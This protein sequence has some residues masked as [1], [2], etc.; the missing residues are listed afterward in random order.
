MKK[1]SHVFPVSTLLPVELIYNPCTIQDIV[2]SFSSFDGDV[3]VVMDNSNHP[4]GLITKAF[5]A[6]LTLSENQCAMTVN[7]LLTNKFSCLDLDSEIDDGVGEDF[8]YI[9]I[10]NQGRIIGALSGYQILEMLFREA[11]KVNLQ[12]A[13]IINSAYNAIVTINAENK[14]T[15]YNRAAEKLFG[16]PKKEIMGKEIFELI[17]NTRLDKVIQTGVV[18]YGQKLN[19]NG[20]TLLSNRAPIIVDG[21][22]IGA[23]AVLQDVTEMESLSNEL[24][25]SQKLNHELD[26]I[27]ESSFDGIYITDGAGNTLRINQAYTRITGITASEV[28]GK[29]MKELVEEGVF[30]Q[31]VTLIVMEKRIPVTIVQEVMKTGKIILVTGNPIFDENGALIRVV[32]NVRDITELNCLKKE[33]EKA[34]SL[35]EHYKEE[36]E[37]FKFLGEKSYIIKSPKMKD[38][39]DL[40]IRLGKVDST[41]LLQAESGCGKEVFADILHQTS[42]RNDKLMIKINCGA[43]PSNLLEAE[44]FGYEPGAFTGASN[45][46]KPGKFELANGGILF[47]DE[48]GEL[49]LDLQVKL[50]RVLQDKEITRLGGTKP[51]QVDVRIIAATNQDLA[52]L[53][54][55]GQFRK[56]LFYRLNVIPVAIPPLRER[57]EEIVPLINHFLTRLNNKYGFSKRFSANALDQMISYA[58][59]GNVRE[60][61]NFVERAFVTSEDDIIN[62]APEESSN[63]DQEISARI[64]NGFS[65]KKELGELEKKLIC[66]ALARFGSTRKA[67]RALGI[68]Q[69]SIV[70]KMSEYKITY[71]K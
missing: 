53:V 23:V 49:S 54:K 8:D 31:S 34:R 56:D 26:S 35:S 48:I 11:Q 55:Q 40:V 42:T 68:S 22:I 63:T 57:Q 6:R 45:R 18:E 1:I 67:A 52:T 7:D 33:V 2:D 65:L 10:Y 69:P 14:I 47:L 44:L 17:S 19:F 29:N 36:L 51:V 46:G 66:S 39:L 16:V 32:T 28:I 30:D 71:G 15:L 20:R 13:T 4:L 59:P 25:F 70:R 3:L 64:E 27:I 60:L 9:L 12:L 58:W 41:V 62:A 50:L 61:E 38:L 24:T 37:K 5:L 21:E 43:I